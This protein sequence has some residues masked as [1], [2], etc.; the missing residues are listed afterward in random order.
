M[1]EPLVR[2]ACWEAS[3]PAMAV[4]SELTAQELLS[5]GSET[6]RTRAVDRWFGGPPPALVHVQQIGTA[7]HGKDT[8]SPSK[9]RMSWSGDPAAETA[10][11]PESPPTV[12]FDSSGWNPAA[13][14]TGAPP[15]L[16]GVRHDGSGGGP[17]SGSYDD[18]PVPLDRTQEWAALLAMLADHRRSSPLNHLDDPALLDALAARL[19]ER[20]LAHIRRA[21]VVDR[22]R[23]GLLVPR[24]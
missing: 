23:S 6:A 1:E 16:S 21:L 12:G 15:P 8:A 19:Q 7:G 18:V 17:G 9:P 24:P 10:S 22:E 20:V 5:G 11:A 2:T 14:W 13:S 4:G 3:P